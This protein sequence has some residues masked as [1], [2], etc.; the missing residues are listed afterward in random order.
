MKKLILL[1]L[2]VS[3][4]A[5]ADIMAVHNLLVANGIPIA[6]LDSNGVIAFAPTATALQKTQG[7]ALV[8]QNMTLLAA[9]AVV[10]D[11]A[12][13]ASAIKA[14]VGGILVANQLMQAYPAFFPAIQS[15]QWKDVQDLILDAQSK[16]VISTSQYSGIKAAAAGYNIPITLP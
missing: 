6:G 16:G 3:L 7:N 10:P 9:P 15:A 5:M 11:G 13:F 1:L 4:P 12:S 14:S 2:F 8:A